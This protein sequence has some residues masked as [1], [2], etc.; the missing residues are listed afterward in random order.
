MI[1][2]AISSVGLWWPSRSKVTRLSIHRFRDL[3]N[4]SNP[5]NFN[6]HSVSSSVSVENVIKIYEFCQKFQKNDSFIN[7]RLLELTE[8]KSFWRKTW[9]I[10]VNKKF[11]SIYESSIPNIIKFLILIIFLWKLLFIWVTLGRM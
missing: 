5:D 9:T 11:F 10:S 1:G 3:I 4:R 8:K 6:L 7:F 2:R